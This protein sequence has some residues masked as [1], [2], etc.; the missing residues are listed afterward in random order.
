MRCLVFFLFLLPISL[1]GQTVCSLES[2]QMLDAMLEKLSQQDHSG[3]S[4]QNLIV[5]IGKNFLGTPYVEKTLELPGAERLVINLTGL[6]CTTYL[7]T[8]VT[9]ARIA[10]QGQLSYE[11]YERELEKLRYQDGT[12]IDYASRLHYFSDWIYQNQ[13][14]GILVDITSEIGG[15]HYPNQPTF[16]SENPRF[17]SQLSDP[18]L[19]KA[20]QADEAEIAKRPYYFIPKA[21]IGAHEQDIESGDLIAITTSLKNLDI[22]HVGFAVEQEGRIH[23][24]HAS[25]G[26]MKVEVS[27]KPLS[28]YLA[29]NKS[30]SGIMVC[31]LTE[32]PLV[33]N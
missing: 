14:K 27:E 25:T 21:E 20:I 26:S 29:G 3:E 2:R 11:S 16:M 8:V 15:I 19:I 23:L 12:S 10:K 32:T 13:G 17:Y 4:I 9:L 24:M 7:E 5:E 1:A 33:Q 18:E 6:D 31:R 30:Q 22:V 28:D